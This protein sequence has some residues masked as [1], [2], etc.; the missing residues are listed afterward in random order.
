VKT[1]MK[2]IRDLSLRKL[3]I[4]VVLTDVVLASVVAVLIVKSTWHADSTPTTFNALSRDLQCRTG[5]DM[6]K[7]ASRPKNSAPNCETK[8]LQVDTDAEAQELPALIHDLPAPRRAPVS[9][10]EQGGARVDFADRTIIVVA[11]IVSFA[12]VTPTVLVV[13]F[14]VLLQ[15]HIERLASLIHIKNVEP[16]FSG[17][18]APSER[19]TDSVRTVEA[20]PVPPAELPPSQG[21]A[22]FERLFEETLELQMQLDGT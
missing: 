22:L 9:G 6:K 1:T 21:G 17:A 13:C 2:M 19:P 16:Q 7:I 18:A 8:A 5:K 4:I 20:T 10:R 15:R 14:F 11:A 3:V 12:F